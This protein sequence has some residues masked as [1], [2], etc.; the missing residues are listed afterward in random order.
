M[1]APSRTNFRLRQ[2]EYAR[3]MSRPPEDPEDSEDKKGGIFIMPPT[4]LHIC[5]SQM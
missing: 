1:K 2:N 3:D 4:N 5:N